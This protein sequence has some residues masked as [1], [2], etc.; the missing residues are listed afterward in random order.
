MKVLGPI[1]SA[2]V[3]ALLFAGCAGSSGSAAT[4]AD[5]RL[6][7]VAAESVWG[8]IASQ[9]GGPKVAVQSVIVNPNTDP[10]SYEPRA[11][12]AI[13]FARSQMAIV[14][15]IGYD[16]WASKLIDSNPS[17]SRTVLDVGDL[18]GLG[19]GDNPH[20]W[21]SP[22]AVERVADRI[23]ADYKRLDPKDAAYFD[24]RRAAF[25]TRGLSEYH[26]LIAQ[27][28]ARYAG[29]PV[30]YSESI[31]QPLG[32]ALGLELMT[33][34]SFAKAISEGTD[35]SAADKQTVDTQAQNR[36]IGVWVY[37]R[38]NATPDVQRVNQLARSAHVAVTTITETLSPAS[39]S[40]E[41]W[42]AA[43]L[44]SLQQALHEATGK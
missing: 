8:S 1:L 18:L 12:D 13:A 28:R 9:L 16:A 20:Q 7:V 31:F 43:E 32:E 42:Q 29:V 14:N 34:Y 2:T 25:Q 19:Q 17:S 3:A 6:Q 41:Q 26:R 39:V 24:H 33:P 5:G 38:Q 27:I 23:A 11:D 21:Y 36:Q 10:H 37:N 40:F 4:A 22:S 35:V 15:G 30:G 44:R